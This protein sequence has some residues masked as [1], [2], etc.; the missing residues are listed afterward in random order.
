A[1]FGILNTLL[2]FPSGSIYPIQAFPKWLRAIAVADP[3][4]YA[5]HGFKSL[6]L[7]ETGL[8]A[9]VPDMIYLTIFAVLT[10]AIATPLF[11]RTL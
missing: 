2:F 9:I 3:F 5:V 1:I 8:G 6:L 7:K 4:T 11:K 10:L